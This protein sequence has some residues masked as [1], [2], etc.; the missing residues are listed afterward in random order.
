MGGG[1]AYLSSAEYDPSNVTLAKTYFLR[2]KCTAGGN[3]LF[4][5]TWT[6][7]DSAVCHITIYTGSGW[8]AKPK[9]NTII[10][11]FIKDSS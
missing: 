7:F 6:S 10:E 3:W 4:L 8:N 5:G 9:Q 11:G 1:A 2:S